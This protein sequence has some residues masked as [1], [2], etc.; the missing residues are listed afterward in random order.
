MNSKHSRSLYICYFGLREPL[1][2]TQVIPYLLEIAKQPPRPREAATPPSKGGELK[3]S[4][5]TFEP[6]SFVKGGK[7]EKALSEELAENGIEWHWLPYHKRPSAPATLYDVLNGARFIAKLMRMEKFDILHARV[8]IPML[9]A[10]I[11]RKIS[12][13]KPK[14]LFDIRGFFP[15]EYIDAGIW[16]ANGLLYR[17]VKRVEK[18]LLKEADGFVVLT[19]K[20]REILFPESRET[21]FDKLRRPVQVIPCC[22]DLEERF[23]MNQFSSRDLLRRDLGFQEKFVIVHLGALGGLYLTEEIVHFLQAAR[24]RD[25]RTFALFLTQTGPER[26]IPFLK[27]AGFSEKDFLVAKV[28]PAEVPKYLAASDVGVSFVKATYATQS[29]SPTK[30]AEYLACGLPIVVNDGVGDTTEF[31]QNDGVGVVIKEFSQNA[32]SAA[33]NE[34]TRMTND[35]DATAQKCRESARKRFDLERVG[36]ERYREL[37]LKLLGS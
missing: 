35:R 23:S 29:R 10:A 17:S 36:G 13:H 33:L 19:E 34:I 12:R 28:P 31:T 1:V 30:N 18:W 15:E 16:K 11:A 6:E 7:E 20:A 14:L 24:E 9:M 4:L 25:P 22:V 32:F 26:I 27:K 21:G 8:H 37:Y 5:L 3:V 2:Q